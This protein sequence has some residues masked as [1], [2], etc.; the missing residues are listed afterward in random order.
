MISTTMI[1]PSY[2]GAARLPT[3]LDSLAAQITD[4]DWEAIIV[5]DGSTDDSLR[6]I[7]DWSSRIPVR[8][9]DLGTNQ[10]RPAALNAGFDAARGRV[11]IRCDDDMGFGP[12]YLARHTAHHVGSDDNGAIGLYRNILPASTYAS[13][14]GENAHER[15]LDSIRTREAAD[16][17]RFWGGNCSVTRSMF[18]RVGPYDPDFRTYGWEDTDWGYRLSLAGGQF[19]L[20]QDLDTDHHGAALTAA[21]RSRR[22]YLAG[23]AQVRFAQK[24]GPVSAG[25][26]G[27]GTERKIWTTAVDLA[28]RAPASI[29][30]AGAHAVA[31]TGRLLPSGVT[32]KLIALAV[33]SSG[34]AGRRSGPTP[35]SNLSEGI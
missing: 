30:E 34:R 29:R 10:G 12:M 27:G 8:A 21:G 4:F 19:I 22:A 17:W 20:D 3:L 2:Q 32:R 13:T 31:R 25:P 15:F 11:L 24:H 7:S 9:I 16:L 6:I 26:V 35:P 5:L 14:Y 18:D 1:V 23:F 28:S 33:E